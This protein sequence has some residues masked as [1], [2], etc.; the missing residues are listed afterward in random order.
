MDHETRRHATATR[1]APKVRSLAAIVAAFWL[2]STA[3]DD[4]V[5]AKHANQPPD[6]KTALAELNPLVGQWRG[7]GQPQRGSRLGAWTEQSTWVWDFAG[8]KT[9]VRYEVAGGKILKLAV[10]TY[11]PKSETYELEATLADDSRRLYSGKLENDRLVLD[12]AADDA[13]DVHRISV[14]RLNPKR[15]LV[16]FEKCRANSD[17]FTRVAEVGYTRAGTSLAEEGAGGAQCIVTGGAG[18]IPVQYKGQTYYVCC[19]GCKQAF[20][21]D[22]E[23]IIADYQRR[24]AEKKTAAE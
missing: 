3:A 9:A 23:G 10:V 20:D 14:T 17:R 22:P 16:L 15:T 2:A 4:R 24:L 7:V 5:N 12:S 18:T 1:C 6:V 19:T 11:D 13:G 21:D 8:K